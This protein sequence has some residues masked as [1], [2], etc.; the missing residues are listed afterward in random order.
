[1][2][3]ATTSTVTEWHWV[4]T[5]QVHRGGSNYSMTTREG[6]YGAATG[7]TRQD[8]YTH[9]MGLVLRDL[10]R[11]PGGQTPGA[12]VLFWSLERNDLD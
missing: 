2:A 12:N 3:S 11:V 8:I 9:V 4:I 6:T 10:P 1:M 7:M 5:L